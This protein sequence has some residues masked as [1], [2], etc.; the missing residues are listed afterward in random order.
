MTVYRYYKAEPTHRQ[1]S[2]SKPILY[3][4]NSKGCYLVFSH[5]RDKDGYVRIL[6]RNK[7]KKK[8]LYL[9]RYVYEIEKGEIPKGKI[10]LHSCDNPSCINPNH[11]SVGTHKDNQQDMTE[12]GRGRIGIRNGRAKLTEKDVINIRESSKDALTLAK[13]YGVTRANIYNIKS[14]K[15]WRHI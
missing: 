5:H 7:G 10:I 12:K 8:M 2:K 6:R 15:T 11:L 14:R 4:K 9:H 13:E 1:A 3:K